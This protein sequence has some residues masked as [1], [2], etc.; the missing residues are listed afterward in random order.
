MWMLARPRSASRTVTRVPGASR[1]ARL[2]VRT[3]LPV[4]PLR[5]AT[6]IRSKGRAP[7]DGDGSGAAAVEGGAACAGETFGCDADG[8]AAGAAAASTEPAG[9]GGRVGGT[10]AGCRVGGGGAA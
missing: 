9:S 7:V 2:L 5:L 4:P 1:T 3:L 10:S 6:L 8:A